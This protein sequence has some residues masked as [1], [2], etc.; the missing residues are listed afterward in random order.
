MKSSKNLCRSFLGQPSETAGHENAEQPPENLPEKQVSLLSP[1]T[2]SIQEVHQG[3]VV[4]GS[5]SCRLLLGGGPPAHLLS[6]RQIHPHCLQTNGPIHLDVPIDKQGEKYST[7]AWKGS[8]E[9]VSGPAILFRT[10]IGP[11]PAPLA[12][13]S[14]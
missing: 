9:W 6:D 2:E 7:N 13:T 10:L 5:H 14:G 8:G 11:H 3:Q 4:F 1:G 12:F